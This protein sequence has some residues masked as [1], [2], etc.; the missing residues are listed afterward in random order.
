MI[1][2]PTTS[3]RTYG[4]GSNNCQDDGCKMINKQKTVVMSHRNTFIK[5][6]KK[7]SFNDRNYLITVENMKI[8]NER[9][10]ANPKCLPHSTDE[11]K[12]SQKSLHIQ[13]FNVLT[14]IIL[15]ERETS[16]FL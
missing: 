5:H 10:A 14:R 4:N 13:K 12:F 8:Y 9:P 16:Y 6:I 11:I 2:T 3:Q 1:D 7:K 15:L